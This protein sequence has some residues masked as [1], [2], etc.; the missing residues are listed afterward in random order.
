VTDP[1]LSSYLVKQLEKLPATALLFSV[2]LDKGRLRAYADH[3]AQEAARLRREA[4][5]ARAQRRSGNPAR[6]AAGNRVDSA[7]NRRAAQALD[8]ASDGA[9]RVVKKLPIIGGVLTVASMGNDIASGESPGQVLTS[10]ALAIGAG[11][12]VGAVAVT[13]GAPVLA[14]AAVGTVAAVGVGML[15]EYAWDHWVPEDVTEAIDEG[16]RDFGE[17]VKDAASDAWDA[18]TPW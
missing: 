11:V 17:G 6:R 16:I 14:V 2:D 5:D 3:T 10:E 12:A 13:L 15:A 9:E 8:V 4:N 7:G 18:V 1:P